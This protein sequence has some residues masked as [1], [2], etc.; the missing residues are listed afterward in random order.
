MMNTTKLDLKSQ[1][2]PFAVQKIKGKPT[3]GQIWVDLNLR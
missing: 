1:G 3:N 2:I